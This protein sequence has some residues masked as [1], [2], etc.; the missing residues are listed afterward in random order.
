M[1]DP[2]GSKRRALTQLHNPEPRAGAPSCVTWTMS[3]PGQLLTSPEN[4]A[5]TP[6]RLAYDTNGPTSIEKPFSPSVL[7]ITLR[8]LGRC[9][10]CTGSSACR[11]EGQVRNSAR[12][13][14]GTDILNLSGNCYTCTISR[15]KV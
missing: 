13:R 8:C 5:L 2:Q 1:L 15:T 3:T 10:S 7:L 6:L 9:A 4:T 14:H 12:L 11:S